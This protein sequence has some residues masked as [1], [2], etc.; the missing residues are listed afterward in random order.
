M[1]RIGGRR[2]SKSIYVHNPID[3]YTY[4]IPIAEDAKIS[5]H[6]DGGSN[7]PIVSYVKDGVLHIVTPVFATNPELITIKIEYDEF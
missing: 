6:K 3:G 2:M 7:E 4:K 1:K 5:V